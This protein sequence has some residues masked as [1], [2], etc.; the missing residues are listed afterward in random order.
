MHLFSAVTQIII[1]TGA[2]IVN[3]KV[4]LDEEE[5]ESGNLDIVMRSWNH[6]LFFFFTSQELRLTRVME[7]RPLGGGFNLM[8]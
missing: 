5:M 2:H 4:N 7:H 8:H 3:E 6:L 1:N